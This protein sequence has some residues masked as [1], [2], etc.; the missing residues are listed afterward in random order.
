MHGSGRKHALVTLA[1]GD[2]YIREWDI[3]CRNNW[4]AYGKRHDCDVIVLTQP[5]LPEAISAERSVHW[6]KLLVPS[7]PALRAY[8]SVA[9]VDADIV[10]N[11]N[12]APSIFAGRD[13]ERIGVVKDMLPMLDGMTAGQRWTWLAMAAARLK[14]GDPLPSIDQHVNQPYHPY[15]AD[16]LEPAPHNFVNTGVIVFSPKRHADFFRRVFNKYPRN[17]LNGD[18]EQTPLSFETLQSGMEEFID[19]RFNTIWTLE[20]ARN[21]PFLFQAR[22]VNPTPEDRADWINMTRNC[23]NA[24]FFNTFFLHF[25]GAP[26]SPWIKSAMYLVDTKVRHLV[27][28]LYPTEQQP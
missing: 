28:T 6:Q 9:W 27:Q 21:Y 15:A 17:S 14:D 7:L 16:R 22:Y 19:S 13:P 8:E 5:V 26:R 12:H 10:I 4:L 11:A 18:F 20:A 3:Y 1:F 2:S 23:V 24:A 25:A